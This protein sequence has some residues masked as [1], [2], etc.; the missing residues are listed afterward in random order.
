M[1]INIQ[2]NNTQTQEPAVIQSSQ[3][4]TPRKGK[5]RTIIVVLLFIV[6]LGAIGALGYLYYST[7]SQLKETKQELTNSHQETEKY[8]EIAE[9]YEAVSTFIAEQND[10]MLSRQLCGGTPVGMFDVHIND[11]F[12]VFRYLCSELT[13]AAPIRIAALKKLQSGAYEFTYGSSS[14]NPNDL[15]GYIY[16]SEPD[17]FG[18]VYGAKKF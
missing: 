17:F 8:K 7:N 14:D 16:D 3:A 2:S 12:A 10:Q 13:S 18:P 1:L 9:N 4:T 15:P 11:K 5:L 6:M